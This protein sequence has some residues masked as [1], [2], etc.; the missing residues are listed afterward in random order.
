MFERGRKRQKK[1]AKRGRRSNSSCIPW[2]NEQPNQST[3]GPDLQLT[4]SL[5]LW[6]PELMLIWS[7]I[8]HMHSKTV[9]HQDKKRY[10]ERSVE[11]MC[12]HRHMWQPNNQQTKTLRLSYMAEEMLRHTRGSTSSLM[13]TTTNL[14]QILK[15]RWWYFN[16]LNYCLW[17]HS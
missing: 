17:T 9:A 3:T 13:T 7:N 6:W 4:S 5:N 14:P 8:Q 1:K 2:E 11:Y 10:S 16:V 15:H 12:K